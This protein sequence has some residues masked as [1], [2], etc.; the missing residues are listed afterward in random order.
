MQIPDPIRPDLDD[1][2]IVSPENLSNWPKIIGVL[3]LIYASI[4]LMCQTSMVA[5]VFLGETFAKMGGMD[6]QVPG[7]MKLMAVASGAILFILGVLMIAGSVNLM[8]R[9]RVGLKLLKIWVIMRVIMIVVGLSL[10]VLMAP[11]NLKMQRSVEEATNRRLREAGQP[12]MPTKTDEQLWRESMI[13]TGVMTGLFAVYPVF[14][15]FFLTRR[16]IVNEAEQWP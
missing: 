7:A 13:W 16:K 11:V 4:G 6:L 3:S 10:T 9:R 12:E 1:Q 14:L 15:G 2:G 5:W 8:R